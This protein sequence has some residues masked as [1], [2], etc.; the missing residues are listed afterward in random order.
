M[1]AGSA[2]VLRSPVFL[3]TVRHLS[4]LLCEICV[5]KQNAEGADERGCCLQ[6]CC[7]F[8]VFGILIFKP[9]SFGSTVMDLVV[10][11]AAAL[12]CVPCVPEAYEETKA[13][14]GRRSPRALRSVT[15]PARRVGI[16]V[17]GIHIAGRHRRHYNPASPVQHKRL[18]LF[19][20]GSSPHGNPGKIRQP[21]CG[22]RFCL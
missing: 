19:K 21:P 13:V 6:W 9:T 7:V 10:S 4:L 18:P 5:S 14:P 1:R 22:E 12:R 17:S 2:G 15:L 3:T 8:L 16:R 20:L 11:G